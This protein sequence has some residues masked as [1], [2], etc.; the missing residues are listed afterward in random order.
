[1]ADIFGRE[2]H[3]YQ[4][5]QDLG[6][7]VYER[8]E[9]ALANAL[10]VSDEARERRFDDLGFAVTRDSEVDDRFKRWNSEWNPATEQRSAVNAQAIG[11]VTDNLLAI[12]G[13]I[14]E[15]LYTGYRADE[16][17]PFR[18]DIGE[19]AT[20]YTPRIVDFHG[21]A[22]FLSSPGLEAEAVR[23]SETID[24]QPLLLGGVD[25]EWTVEDLRN[26]MY[27]GLPLQTLTLEGAVER[28]YDHIEKVALQG[29]TT[30][31]WRGL[32]NLTNAGDGITT[33]AASAT[34]DSSTALQIQAAIAGEIGGLITDT[35]EVVGRKIR[36]GLCVYLPG[37]E[38]DLLSSPLG[39]NADKSIMQ[40][41]S[42]MNPFTA[43]TGNNVMFKRLMELQNTMLTTV[44]SDRVFEMG[45][46]IQPRIVRILD[47]GRVVH[48]QLEYKIGRLYVKRPGYIRQLTG[49]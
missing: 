49:I 38:F 47:K 5:Y 15:I 2:R 1:M 39:D 35:N 48:G 20:S 11:Y 3:E 45:M 25:A 31:S 42:E 23:V 13:M 26:A 6:H 19:G 32:S 22:K 44:M 9:R 46:P 16:F 34:F 28:C 4:I 27:T 21:E 30:R 10:G 8:H 17:V 7:E 36:D 37:T 12:T 41:L 18:M 29:D 33:N 40:W 14:E 43:M 24:P